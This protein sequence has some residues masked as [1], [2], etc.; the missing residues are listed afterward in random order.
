MKKIVLFCSLL[1]TCLCAN[2]QKK[3]TIAII[4]TNEAGEKVEVREGRFDMKY[5]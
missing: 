4:K 1:A 5:Q 3:D 2:A